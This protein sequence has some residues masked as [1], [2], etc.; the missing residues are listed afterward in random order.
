MKS[1]QEKLN[2][3]AKACEPVLWDLL[4]SCVECGKVLTPDDAYG[5]DCEV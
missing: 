1:L 2:A 4:N 3:A 5:H